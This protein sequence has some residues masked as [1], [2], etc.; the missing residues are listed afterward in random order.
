MFLSSLL[1]WIG[2]S[3]PGAVGGILLLVTGWP[4]W[5]TNV[6]AMLFGAVLLPLSAIGLTLQFYDFR[7]EEVRDS[8]PTGTT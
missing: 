4:F 1:V 3:V 7:Q 5:I 6:V 2:F 8:V